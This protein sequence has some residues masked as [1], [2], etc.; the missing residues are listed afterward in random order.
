[1]VRSSQEGPLWSVDWGSF[2]NARLGPVGWVV[3]LLNANWTMI[4]IG[5]EY[6]D[7]QSRLH[8]I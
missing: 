3:S 5:I 2:F 1:M 4:T 8:M 7:A 6:W